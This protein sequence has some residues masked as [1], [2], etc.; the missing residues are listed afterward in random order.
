MESTR[1]DFSE[2]IIGKWDISKQT[3]WPDKE[4]VVYDTILHQFNFKNDKTYESLSPINHNLDYSGK[5]NVSD[6]EPVT[7]TLTRDSFWEA[8][9]HIRDFDKSFFIIERPTDEGIVAQTYTRNE[10]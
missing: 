2:I 1:S 3:G 4:E 5:F 7:I 6:E 8:D 9:F 10:D